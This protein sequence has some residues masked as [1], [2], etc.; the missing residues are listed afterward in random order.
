M[1]TDLATSPLL[2]SIPFWDDLAIEI[3]PALAA[4]WLSGRARNR[5]ITQSHVA[6]LADVIR[7]GDWVPTNDA[8]TFNDDNELTNGQHRLSAIVETGVAERCLVVR[9]VDM[10]ALDTGKKRTV[11]DTFSMLGHDNSLILAAAVAH[12]WRL[13]TP[14]NRDKRAP[15]PMEARRIL[16][17]NPDLPNSLPF[18]WGARGLIGPGQATFVHY[19]ASRIDKDKA[20]EFLMRLADGVNL[21]QDSPILHLRNRLLAHRAGDTLLNRNAMLDLTIKAWNLFEAGIPTR[22]LRADKTPSKFRDAA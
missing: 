20:D 3:T 22:L 15:N 13:N 17:A 7:N 16:E 4:E 2:S 14:Y 21:P 10:D 9:G 12:L 8:I 1:N 11:A 6:S 19:M 18:G 5:H